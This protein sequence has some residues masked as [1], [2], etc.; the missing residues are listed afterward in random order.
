[1]NKEQTLFL[2]VG[3]EKK[4]FCGASK[5]KTTQESFME[6]GKFTLYLLLYCTLGAVLRC[7]RDKGLH[8]KINTMETS[9]WWNPK[10]A[11]G[12]QGLNPCYVSGKKQELFYAQSKKMVKEIFHFDVI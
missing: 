5:T 12:E 10:F 11:C 3:L 1:M 2:S 6:Q 7:K 4:N 9:Q 8:G